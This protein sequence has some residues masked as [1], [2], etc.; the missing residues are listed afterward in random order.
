LLLSPDHAVFAAGVLIPVKHLINGTS[1]RQVTLAEVTYHHIALPSHSVIWA[2]G[3]PT[4]SYLDT[5][6]RA[7]FAGATMALHPAWGGE[8]RDVA[9]IFDALGYAPLCVTGPQVDAVRAAI[10]T[11]PAADKPFSSKKRARNH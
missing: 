8:A 10:G 9:V 3:L 4:E 1:I 2:E 11:E 7:S 5:G 6:D